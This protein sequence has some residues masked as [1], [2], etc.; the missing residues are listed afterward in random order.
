MS[1]AR[2]S[3]IG[4][5][6]A[7]ALALAFGWT[8]P[9]AQATDDIVEG[10]QLSWNHSV[11][12]PSRAYTAGVEAL[13]EELERRTDGNWTLTIHYGGA[14]SDPQDQLDN[15]QIGAFEMGSFCAGFH[16]GKNPT[17]N[18][19]D[20][21]FLPTA[22]LDVQRQVT[23][24]YFEHPAVQEDMARWNVRVVPN[25]QPPNEVMGKGSSPEELEDWRGQRVRALGGTASALELVGAVP[26]TFPPTEIYENLERGVIDAASLPMSYAFLAYAVEEQTDWYTTNLGISVNTCPTAVN[27][28]AWNAL[29]PEYQELFEEAVSVAQDALKEAYAEADDKYFDTLE[30]RGLTEVRYSEETLAEFRERAGEPLWEEWV[31]QASAQGLPAQELLDLIL[32]T[33][34]EAGAAGG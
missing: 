22:D 26:T 34:E 10:P 16:P 19:L 7:S 2:R 9:S 12:G 8:V 25:I 27:L 1:S 6:G 28:D 30:E 4:L 24:A 11:W 33:A 31:E 18:A 15:L 17:I 20:L 3:A 5:C 13:A 21:P 14:L 23:E 32:D 29:P